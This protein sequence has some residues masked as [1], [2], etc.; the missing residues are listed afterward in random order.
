MEDMEEI[1][2]QKCAETI[3]KF[4]DI[5]VLKFEDV[6]IIELYMPLNAKDKVKKLISLL[7]N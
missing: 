6:P 3:N 1:I 5:C 4:K 2:S 7:K